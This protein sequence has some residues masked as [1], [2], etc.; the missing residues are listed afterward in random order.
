L[1]QEEFEDAKRVIRIR[2]YFISLSNTHINI[3]LSGRSDIFYFSGGQKL[4]FFV[5][6]KTTGLFPPHICAW[7]RRDRDRMV[8]GLT[9]I[10]AISAYHH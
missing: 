8:V 1:V 6:T 2:M 10:Y 9:T 5:I 7:D 3:D 4:V